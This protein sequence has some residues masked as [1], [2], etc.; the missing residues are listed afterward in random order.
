MGAIKQA[1][2]QTLL[3]NV[4]INCMRLVCKE[5]MRN[6][7]SRDKQRYLPCNLYFRSADVGPFSIC[8]L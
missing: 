6:L 2:Q 3:T 7:A 8:G 1:G 5:C 4:P